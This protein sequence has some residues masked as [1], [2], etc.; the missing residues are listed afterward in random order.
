VLGPQLEKVLLVKVQVGACPSFR[1]DY[2]AVAILTSFHCHA[3]F[4]R[5]TQQLQIRASVGF[6]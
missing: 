3:A 5:I 6:H 1:H 4:V 2:P